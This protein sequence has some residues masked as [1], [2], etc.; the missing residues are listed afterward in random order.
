MPMAHISG[1][2]IKQKKILRGNINPSINIWGYVFL[3]STP[4]VSDNWL[5][6]Q[7]II[8]FWM[9]QNMK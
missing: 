8:L 2:N 9:D 6:T 7:I 4:Y 3:R 5:S 1:K